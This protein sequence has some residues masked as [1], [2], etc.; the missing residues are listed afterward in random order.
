MASHTLQVVVSKITK[1]YLQHWLLNHKHLIK[2]IVTVL[3]FNQA[4]KFYV[5]FK[6]ISVMFWIHMLLYF[7]LV[8]SIESHTLHEY[9][10]VRNLSNNK[11]NFSNFLDTKKAFK[12]LLNIN[13]KVLP[14]FVNKKVV[15][16]YTNISRTSS[17]ATST[18]CIT[19]R[20]GKWEILG[21]STRVKEF[22]FK[23]VLSQFHLNPSQMLTQTP[24]VI[25]MNLPLY[26][27]IVFNDVRWFSETRVSLS[28]SLL[29]FI[30]KC[31]L[32][33]ESTL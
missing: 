3:L 19:Y 21:M 2:S 31:S 8:L 20:A 7:T 9:L 33:Y 11:Q 24:S 17:I 14:I 23:V 25:L 32:Y 26:F 5:T 30:W 13:Q 18:T 22:H 12:Y 4:F 16:Y 1:P 28:K 29:Q 15:K 6:Q 10:L 27:L